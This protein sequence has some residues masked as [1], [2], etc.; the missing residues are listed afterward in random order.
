MLRLLK[1]QNLAV[2]DAA[3]L[4]LNE[5]FI[6]LTGESGAGKSIIIE[7]LQ[8]L[9]GN[10]A[11]ADL[12]RQGC[13]KAIVEAEFELDPVY[14]QVDRSEHGLE[15]LDGTQLFLR[16]EISK[17]GKSR[18]F[19]NGALVPNSKLAAYSE[20]VFE[21]HG[22]HGQQKL[23]QE[24]EHQRM[25][26]AR[27]GLSETADAF[28]KQVRS[29]RKAF[30]QYW[31]LKDGEAARLKELDFVQMQ[32]DEIEEVNPAE[33]DLELD[34]RLERE[35]NRENIKRYRFELE[36]LLDTKLL[37]DLSRFQSTLDQ[38]AQF[39]KPLEPYVEQVE[40][41]YATLSDLQSEVTSLA[42][43]TSEAGAL[44]ELEGRES[45]LNKLFMKYGRDVQ[46]VIDEL[47]R[48]KT[49]RNQLQEEAFGLDVRWQQLENEYK[50]L[51]ASKH[52]L[53]KAREK[54]S[55]GF[56]D[57]VCDALKD[58]ALLRAAFSVTFD[59][60]DWPKT[61]LLQRDLDLALPKLRFLFSANP[62]EPARPL[63]KVAS[64]G[65][66]SR[67]ML[68]LISTLERK[69]KRLLVFDEIDAGLGGETA[70]AI[71]A[72]L[73]QLGVGHQVFCVTHFAQVARFAN[74]QI[75]IGKRETEG[76]TFSYLE[77]CDHEGRVT[78]LA[79]LLGGD[80]AAQNLRDHARSLL[81]DVPLGTE[82]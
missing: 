36:D 54:A 26:D 82:N 29:F 79:R 71:G 63:S 66:M 74:Q 60:S 65:E 72:K 27:T 38:L 16:R 37:P 32:I 46:E 61:L 58:L 21:I 24:R 4:E 43:D 78:E 76:R 6:C 30:E 69:S 1:V 67:V 48:L 64:G 14:E 20:L 49:R 80:S 15:L 70:H 42:D 44:I 3:E 77:L 2:I 11:S 35:R 45:A 9:S 18:G 25:F 7:A 5:G 75:K 17:E 23:M 31:D 40:S 55:S 68:A 47:E 41:L 33:E 52:A 73:A 53:E 8:L 59:A 51:S 12:I 56:S 50:A 39:E 57:A 81:A 19:V 28:R 13:D 34:Q 22:Q 62:G 10:R